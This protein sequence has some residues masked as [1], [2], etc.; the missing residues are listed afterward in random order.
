MFSERCHPQFLL[1]SLRH[2]SCCS[3]PLLASIARN[4]LRRYWL[5]PGQE[6]PESVRRGVLDLDYWLAER[7]AKFLPPT[8]LDEM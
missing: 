7:N 5:L 8:P 6:V 3:F 4:P 1:G 2:S